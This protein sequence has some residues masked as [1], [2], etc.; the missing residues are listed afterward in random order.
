MEIAFLIAGMTVVT[1]TI[2]YSMIVI[3]GRWVIPPLAH[4]ALRFVPIAA[5][6]AIIAPGLVSNSNSMLGDLD[7]SRLIAAG[8]AIMV[9]VI[10]RQMLLTIAVGMGAMWIIQYIL[11]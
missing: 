4:R 11:R 9:A 5:F 6:A 7:L 1:Y 3:L 8:L 2:R 10:T